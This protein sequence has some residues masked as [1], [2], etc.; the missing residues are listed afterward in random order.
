MYCRGFV[1]NIAF[2]EHFTLTAVYIIYVL[3]YYNI[4]RENKDN[5]IYSHLL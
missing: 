4:I 3:V 5:I 2:N 1:Q